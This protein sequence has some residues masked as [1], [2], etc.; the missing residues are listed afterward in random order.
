M[1]T[2][3]A[4]RFVC[5]TSAAISTGMERRCGPIT[6]PQLSN[7]KAELEIRHLHEKVDHLVKQQWQRLVEIQQIQSELME[8][9]SERKR[10]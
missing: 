5:Y 3:P 2:H 8:E 1:G 7:D 10:R 6:K 4:K 9:L